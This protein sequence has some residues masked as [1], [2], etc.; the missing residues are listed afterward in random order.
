M[1]LSN[2]YLTI[3]VVLSGVT[4]TSAASTCTLSSNE[5]PAH[6]QWSCSL[7]DWVSEHTLPTKRKTL[8]PSQTSIVLYPESLDLAGELSVRQSHPEFSVS[9]KLQNCAAVYEAFNTNTGKFANVISCGSGPYQFDKSTY[10]HRGSHCS[11]SGNIETC[12]SNNLMV[13]PVQADLTYKVPRAD[14]SGELKEIVKKNRISKNLGLVPIIVGDITTFISAEVTNLTP[15]P[16]NVTSKWSGSFKSE[17]LPSAYYE[18]SCV[19][20]TTVPSVNVPLY[21]KGSNLSKIGVAS[22]SGIGG[23]EPNALKTFLIRCGTSPVKFAVVNSQDLSE[24]HW[25]VNLD[26]TGGTE[27]ITE[28]ERLAD[29]LVAEANS[30]IVER[31]S[32]ENLLRSSNDM[33]HQITQEM[34]TIW[35]RIA[36][37]VFVP[38]FFTAG[39][40]PLEFDALSMEWTLVMETSLHDPVNSRPNFE[41]LNQLSQQTSVGGIENLFNFDFDYLYDESGYKKYE[42]VHY[43]HWE[44]L[45]SLAQLTGDIS[46]SDTNSS[47]LRSIIESMKTINSRKILALENVIEHTLAVARN[48]R[49]LDREKLEALQDKLAEL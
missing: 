36:T 39:Y 31:Q 7:D 41:K 33:K 12:V 20:N 1:K 23:F 24:P 5:Y 49:S 43:A 4:F 16:T 19:D 32:L 13:T 14:Y 29:V 2:L 38:D 35:D 17:V 48:A 42:T 3:G 47:D 46:Y 18:L 44:F 9:R 28:L 22:D 6:A 11:V 34:A 30:L 25:R 40:I 8:S 15:M 21:Y 10:Y 26:V 27:Y 45:I 37:T